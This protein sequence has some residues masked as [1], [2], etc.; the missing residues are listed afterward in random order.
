M[1]G[2]FVVMPAIDPAWAYPA[3]DACRLP[4]MVVDNSN[5]NRGVMRS[6]NLG[7][8]AF[9]ASDADWFIT[10]SSSLILGPDGGLDFAEQ[11]A[12][13]QGDLGVA[14]GIGTWGW[15]FIAFRRDVVE[16]MGRYDENFTPYGL[17]DIDLSIRIHKAMPDIAWAGLPVGIESDRVMA[18]SIKSGL[19]NPPYAPIGEYFEEKWGV[20]PG[21]EFDDYWDHPFN[22]PANGINFWPS[23][24]D[25]PDPVAHSGYWNLRVDPLRCS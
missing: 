2:V 23:Y 16:R 22:D 12:A 21:H 11:L 7:I 19:V 17:D 13:R 6:H 24:H 10:M 18:H 15:H 8:D 20:A 14:S 5:V 25:N 3:I 9:M 1:S 4:L